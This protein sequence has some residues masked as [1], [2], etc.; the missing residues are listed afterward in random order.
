MSLQGKRALITGAGSGIGRATAVQMAGEGAEVYGLDVVEKNLRVTG[1]LVQQSG[2]KW[3]SV[4]ADVSDPSQIRDAIARVMRDWERIDI[5]VNVAGVVSLFPV[6]E[7]PDE[8][9]DRVLR[10]NLYG[11]FYLCKAVVPGM[12]VRGGGSIVN[13]ASGKAFRGMRNGAHYSA[14]KGGMV[15][16]TYSLAD[17]LEGTGVRVNAV[18][19]GNTATPMTEALRATREQAGRPDLVLGQPPED[20]GELI[21]FLASD[22]SRMINGQAVGRVRERGK[23]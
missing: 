7:M 17:E 15:S 21:L 23:E 19:P 2:G 3:N 18:V 20:V 14:S 16:F 1:E 8:E 22:K 9:W 13:V 10:V 6:T 11:T 12:V 5:L 4:T